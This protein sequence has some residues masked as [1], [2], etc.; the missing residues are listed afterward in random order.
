MDSLIY[1]YWTVA[2]LF[3]YFVFLMM[4]RR[5]RLILP[6]VVCTFIWLVTAG[7]VI[8]Q[9]KGVLGSYVLK[10][11]AVDL[12][13][14]F[15]CY[16]AIASVIGF[17]CAHYVMA[18]YESVAVVN[19]VDVSLV[20][21]L[22]RRFKWIPYL[23]AATGVVLFVF[24]I[25]TVGSFSSLSDYRI[26]AIQTERVGYAAIAQRISGH[27][28]IW[29]GF[30]LMLLGYKSGKEGINA[31]E[32]L[33]Y[34]FLCSVINMAIGGRVWILTS[35]LPFF[36]TY[37]LSVKYNRGQISKDLKTIFL[38]LGIFISAFALIGLL[39]GG[40]SSGSFFDKFLYLTDGTRMTNMVL[41]QY[42][43]MTF[44]Q[45]YGIS[46][47]L[48]GLVQSP[49]YSRFVQFISHD[50]GLSVTV[51][52]IMPSLYYDFGFLG[53]PVFWGIICFVVEALSIR[54][55]YS[56]SILGLL[57]FGTL[58]AMLFQ[59]PVGNVFSLYTP[60]FEWLL[61]L[62][63]FRKYIFGKTLITC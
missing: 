16:M 32:F 13:S 9:L 49:M 50:I 11:R 45:E 14:Q 59:S 22:L 61:L 43:E 8:F 38:I 60:T 48:G 17:S 31:Q 53:G 55:K 3:V 35:T 18:R 28:N 4:Q 36:T 29:G 54:L 2:I 56:K 62:F 27:I 33:L 7:L 37:F 12:V 26:L 44:P 63:I 52:S 46:T 40:Q 51:K 41:H 15:T 25:T 21:D 57:L 23:C 58:S 34:A 47:L 20:E 24:L 5:Y 30:Y 19:S 39:R 42:P 6:S 10:D 1:Y